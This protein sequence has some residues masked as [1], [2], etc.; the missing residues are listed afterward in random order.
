MSD[1]SFLPDDYVAQ[2]AERRTNVIC[3]VLFVVVMAGV[4]GAFLVTN[5]QW[6][7]VKKEQEQM[8][9]R[10]QTV[11]EEIEELNQLEEQKEE[12]LHK[13]ELAAA[14][15]ERVPR[16]I[17]LAELIN[18]M[19]DRLSLLQFELKSDQIKTG[20][21][22]RL[23]REGAGRLGKP[24]RART[25]AE[26]AADAAEKPG[27]PTYRVSIALVGAAPT[28]LE[29]SRYLSALNAYPLLQ[30]V[31][32]EYSE[33]KEIDGRA[34]RQF[35]VKMQLDPDADVRMIDATIDSRRVLNPMGDQLKFAPGNRQGTALVPTGQDGDH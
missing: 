27:A 23:P 8:S 2:K 31:T 25:K 11:A 20:P 30:N 7:R 35:R 6:V 9:Q 32:L 29:V 33:R 18:R 21:V 17:L 5:R 3:F 15:V 26:A 1:K 4:F 19:P 22:R 16:S 13:A 34:M 14:L 24:T 28:D 10:Y 12:V